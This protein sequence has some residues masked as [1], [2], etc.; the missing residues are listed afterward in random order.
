MSCVNNLFRASVILRVV[1][2]ILVTVLINRLS[3]LF[4]HAYEYR[5]RGQ[6]IIPLT[7]F[8]LRQLPFVL[9][10]LSLGVLVE[11]LFLRS[12][13][14]RFLGEV[15]TLFFVMGCILYCVGSV[16]PF[17]IYDISLER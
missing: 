11:A 3:P 12:Y 1:T 17:I 16:L 8:V 5:L 6:P 9:L 2:C 14:Q 7:E 13:R 10:L 4:L 15:L